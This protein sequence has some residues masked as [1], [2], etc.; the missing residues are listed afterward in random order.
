MIK[1]GIVLSLI[2]LFSALPARADLIQT[3][4]GE[5]HNGEVQL[6][7]FKLETTFG[8]WEFPR[9]DLRT[10]YRQK[11]Y[12]VV[13]T[14]MGERLKGR[15]ID[16]SVLTTRQLGPDLDIALSEISHIAFSPSAELTEHARADVVE[17]K[18]GDVFLV[19]P[20]VSEIAL[21]MVSGLTKFTR[22]QLGAMDVSYSEDQETHMAR[23]IMKEGRLKK[24]ILNTQHLKVQ[25]IYGDELS[26][27]VEEI[28][29]V[30][31][32]VSVKNQIA[33]DRLFPAIY[34]SEETGKALQDRFVNGV[35]GPEMVV[36]PPGRYLRGQADGDF[37]EKPVQ[38]VKISNGFAMSRYEI[39][40][41][42]F[43]AYCLEVN[44]TLPDD[45]DWGTGKRPIIN[46]SWKEANAYVAW[47]SER[48]GEVYRLPTDAEW[49]YAARAGT[50][51]RYYWGQDVGEEQANCAGCV[52]IWGSE[53]TARVGR[54][55][56]NAFGLYD[57]AGNV[58]EWTQDCWNNT[59]ENL[60][61]DG[62]SY[63]N[64]TGCGKRVIRGGGWSFPPN[65]VR[66]ANRWREFPTRRSDD[67]G[68]RVVRELN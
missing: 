65:E 11:N 58:F 55:K 7:S 43:Q 49:E 60:G 37:D 1:K 28:S 2:V 40:F 19:K 30:L 24:G 5:F 25:N 14:N 15:L 26:L 53:R 20:Y 52:T 57:M 8:V 45:S 32:D 27:P 46:V 4:R 17:I 29:L 34:Q 16:Q 18:N 61:L 23:L 54:F 47:L 31:F 68:F 38:E 9:S 12:D 13:T 41:D 22:D 59:F 35:W 21:E 64:P 50:Q 66:S 10:I 63:E 67:T 39:T 56:P 33:G 36:I 42:D 62:A 44:C 51:T 48:T 6:K 3:V